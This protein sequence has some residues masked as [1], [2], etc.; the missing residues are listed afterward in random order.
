[1]TLKIYPPAEGS[2][3]LLILRV[4]GQPGTAALRRRADEL[5]ALV[6]DLGDDELLIRLQPG[7]QVGEQVGGRVGR[8]LDRSA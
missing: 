5:G 3:A 2:P 4:R 1:V 7:E 6:S 8:P